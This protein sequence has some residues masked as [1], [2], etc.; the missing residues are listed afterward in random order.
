M[1]ILH[2]PTGEGAAPWLRSCYMHPEDV[3][4]RWGQEVRRGERIGTVGRTGMTSSAPHLHLELH[5][6]D[7]L[8][9]PSEHLAAPSSAATR[10]RPS[11]TLSGIA[12][13]PTSR[14]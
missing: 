14:P 5:G 4:V 7:G 12:S 9:D 6:P 11:S 8:M 2:R 3:E 10:R 1:C 13:A